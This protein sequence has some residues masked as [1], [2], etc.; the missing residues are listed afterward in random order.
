MAPTIPPH[1]SNPNT[2]ADEPVH[3]FEGKVIVLPPGTKAPPRPTAAVEDTDSDLSLTPP[4][5]ESKA[6]IPPPGTKAPPRP[7]S[8]SELDAMTEGTNPEEIERA[9]K[10]IE[11]LP[12][13]DRVA[14]CVRYL[15]DV[16]ADDLARLLRVPVGT[17]HEWR[18]QSPSVT[19]PTFETD[20]ATT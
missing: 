3:T 6:V 1:E 11:D 10:A 7:G 5:F 19:G 4:V 15:G 16:P 8:A 12:E 18:G 13:K 9:R 14:L 2:F 17:I 20:K